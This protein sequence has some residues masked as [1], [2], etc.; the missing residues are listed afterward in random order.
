VLSRAGSK[1]K[2]FES[3]SGEESLEIGTDFVSDL[4][5]DFEFDVSVRGAQLDDGGQWLRRFGQDS[6]FGNSFY[7]THFR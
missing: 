5:R 6:H 7:V 2:S 1:A 3:S 4:F